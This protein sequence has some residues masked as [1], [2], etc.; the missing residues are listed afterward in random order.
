MT[1]GSDP[2]QKHVIRHDVD[3]SA[4]ESGLAADVCVSRTRAEQ[5]ADEKGQINDDGADQQ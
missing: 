5:P 1:S 2:K 4:D 3:L